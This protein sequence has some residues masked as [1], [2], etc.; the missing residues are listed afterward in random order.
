MPAVWT[1]IS[2]REFLDP[3]RMAA[4]LAAQ[5]PESDPRAAL[6][7]HAVTYGWLCGEL[8]RRVDGRTLGRFFAEEV[9]AP[10]GLEL[11]IGLPESLEAR[12]STLRYGPEWGLSAVGRDDAYPGDALWAAMWKSLPLFP[13]DE[14][15]WNRRAW[16]AAELPASNAIGTARS[17]AR[18]Y[19][20]L[21]CGGTLDGVRL[22]SAEGVSTASTPFASGADPWVGDPMCFGV[23]FSLQ[24]A[25]AGYGPPARA[26]GH[27]GAGGSIHGAWPDLR[28]GFS[29]AM[30]ELRDDPAGDPR[31]RALLAV[32]H[33]RVT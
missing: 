25:A 13:S 15:P 30:N 3:R 28:V 21:A 9:A 20:A 12:V 19:G 4:L 16:H 5:A 11:W 29:Y 26:F 1:R 33:D 2:E 6:V 22:L 10:L 32:L 14:L 31:A 7:Y 24:T 27:S 18:L 23:G 17:I 8:V